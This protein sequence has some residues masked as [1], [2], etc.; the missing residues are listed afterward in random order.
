MGVPRSGLLG[1]GDVGFRG[2][3]VKL[4][5]L[6]LG[7]RGVRRRRLAGRIWRLSCG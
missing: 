2:G 6:G 7:G 5:C 4:T 1:E 3:W